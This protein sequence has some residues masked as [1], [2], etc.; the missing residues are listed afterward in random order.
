MSSNQSD[1]VTP[2]S[3]YGEI[4]T[5]T[6]TFDGGT[7]PPANCAGSQVSTKSSVPSAALTMCCSV[8]AANPV[9]GK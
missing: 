2:P 9:D 4:D 7:G 6:G 5:I 3:R 1:S 8:R